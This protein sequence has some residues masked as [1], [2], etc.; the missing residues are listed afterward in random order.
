M[1]EPVP[2]ESLRTLE[3]DE[4]ARCRHVV[5]RLTARPREVLRAFAAGLTLQEVAEQMGV[6]IGTVHAHKT[7]I[8]E[9]CRVAW[10]LPPEM[11]LSSLWLR[12]RFASY[13]AV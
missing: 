11:R 13:F 9:E 10:G 4:Y 1:A 5:E 8:F 12:D 2:D 7:T 6:T 3:T